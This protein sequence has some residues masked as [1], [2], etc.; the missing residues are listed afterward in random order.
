MKAVFCEDRSFYI[1]VTSMD[2]ADEMSDLFIFYS[3]RRVD[4]VLFRGKRRSAFLSF[5][6]VPLSSFIICEYANFIPR[7]FS[8]F[9]LKR[10]ESH[11]FG[12]LDIKDLSRRGGSGCFLSFFR[13]I[14]I[15]L[16]ADRYVFYTSSLCPNVDSLNCAKV[17]CSD[18][19][20]YLRKVVNNI[21]KEGLERKSE[22]WFLWIG[23]PLLSHGFVSHHDRMILCLRALLDHGKKVFY[24]AHPRE[25]DYSVGLVEDVIG[26]E[27]IVQGVE[28]LISLFYSKGLP[29]TVFSFFSSLAYELE[30]SGLDVVIFGKDEKVCMDIFRVWI[31]RTNEIP[32]ISD[33]D[34]K[35][36][37]KRKDAGSES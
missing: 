9:F 25:E 4:Y 6:L 35:W 20:S 32:A 21:R 26:K 7:L 27:N 37:A 36:D 29:S 18:Q 16:Q 3:G 5:F 12:L 19:K 2:I 34:N 15:P 11:V 28:G 24:C 10:L 33:I 23:Q 17:V 31:K 1:K 8:V 14:I 13:K 30:E 22:E